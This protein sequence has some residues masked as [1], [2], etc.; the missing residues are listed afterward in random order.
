[1]IC[2]HSG[3]EGSHCPDL[4]ADLRVG[5]YR[6]NGGGTHAHEEEEETTKIFRLSK[7]DEQSP[8]KMGRI[9]HAKRQRRT[10]HSFQSSYANFKCTTFKLYTTKH[11]NL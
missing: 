5:F 8:R 9:V 6:G 10:Y 1:M 4:V 11:I 7:T 3:H 2:G